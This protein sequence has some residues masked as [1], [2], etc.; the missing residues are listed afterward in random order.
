MFNCTKAFD[1]LLNQTLFKERDIHFPKEVRHDVTTAT[2][3][4]NTQKVL[5]AM[6]RCQSLLKVKL[7]KF[8]KVKRKIWSNKTK[9][10]KR[11]PSSRLDDQL[12]SGILANFDEDK[13]TLFEEANVAYEQVIRPFGSI[14]PDLAAEGIRLVQWIYIIAPWENNSWDAIFAML[15]FFPCV[16]FDI[17]PLGRECWLIAAPMA[18]LYRW[19]MNLVANPFVEPS[20]ELVRFLKFIFSS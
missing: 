6:Y 4:N 14:I 20:M 9:G 2:A 7:P 18:G 10:Y 15:L 1:A 8:K 3:N 5:K 12:L 11:I 17:G 16:E 13:A 19:F